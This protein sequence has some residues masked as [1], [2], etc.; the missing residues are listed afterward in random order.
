MNALIWFPLL[1]LSLFLLALL[2]L[3]KVLTKSVAIRLGVAT[4]F[5]LLIFMLF[6]WLCVVQVGSSDALKTMNTWP[7]C[8]YVSAALGFE[9][10]VDWLGIIVLI[11]A[12]SLLIGVLMALFVTL[13]EYINYKFGRKE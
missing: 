1:L 11:F 12:Y 3:V 2:F 10:Q 9:R 4:W 6:W 8:N 13:I 7:L 5:L